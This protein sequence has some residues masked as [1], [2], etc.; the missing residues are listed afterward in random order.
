MS[1]DDINQA[2]PIDGSPRDVRG[3]SPL[4]H[5]LFVWARD[6][7]PEDQQYLFDAVSEAV[8]ATLTP[9]QVLVMDAAGECQRQLGRSVSE[10]VYRHWWL[11]LAAADPETPPPWPTVDQAKSAFAGR[12]SSIRREL[13]ATRETPRVNLKA[14]VL[15]GLGTYLSEEE[16]LS[17]L[18]L[19]WATLPTDGTRDI[20]FA[21]YRRWAVAQKSGLTETE[22]RLVR[23]LPRTRG[24][25]PAQG[26]LYPC[27]LAHL[28]T[29]PA[30]RG[31]VAR[32]ALHRPGL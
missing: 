1:G 4:A 27:S 13:H 32:R 9:L 18:R 30:S 21:M 26:R 23:L 10:D 3:V 31:C 25:S 29:G 6:Q 7:S 22:R 14:T 8:G 5:E 16:L 20:R 28:P 24:C 17:G 15:M 19:W 11:G 12:W 2:D